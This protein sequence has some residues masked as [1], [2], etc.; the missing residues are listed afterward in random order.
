MTYW[1]RF[2]SSMTL[3]VV[4]TLMLSGCG[5]SGSG[6]LDE[7]KEPHFLAGKERISTLD[8]KGAIDSF[9]KA[10]QANPRSAA[11]HFELAWIY[12]QK[13]VDPAAA[14]Y[15][16]QR[17]LK[18]RPNADNSDLAKQRIIACKQAL[19][20]T[21]SLGPVTER[22]QRQFEETAEDKKRLTEENKRLR[23]ELE[24]WSAYAA[25]LQTLTNQSVVSARPGQTEAT[26]QVLSVIQS[27]SNE[28][29]GAKP[30]GPAAPNSAPAA[31]THMV[32][33]GETP[34]LIARKY[35]VK[36]EA[37]MAANPNLEPRRLRVGQALR[38]P[39]A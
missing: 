30:A 25:R 39:G 34:S 23:E 11:A 32:K 33:S 2:L 22:I 27:R 12:D 1:A 26:T 20:E 15:H 38:I 8:W 16:Y 5:P 7:E 28:P 35:G 17:F 36:L 18:L 4:W 9:E 37:L 19:A 13:E 24:K 21:V 10:L 6:P 29:A 14:I 3:L 31:R